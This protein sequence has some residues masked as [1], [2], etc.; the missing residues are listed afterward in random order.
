M[1]MQCETDVNARCETT[2]KKQQ[3][4]GEQKKIYLPIVIM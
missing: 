4:Q 3:Q 2:N 1:R